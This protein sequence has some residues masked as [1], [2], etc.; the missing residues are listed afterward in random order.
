MFEL[1]SFLPILERLKNSELEKKTE[2]NKEL[3]NLIEEAITHH[4]DQ[5]IPYLLDLQND[6]HD[7]L[8]E[9]IFDDFKS[10]VT[11][12]ILE[13]IIIIESFWDLYRE[14]RGQGE[15]VQ[16]ALVLLFK[17]RPKI[18]EKILRDVLFRQLIRRRDNLQKIEKFKNKP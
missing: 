16:N 5:V 1:S 6:G 7:Q 12:N 10:L 4:P 8:L 9:I 17:H 18:G 13:E 14:S 2:A 3:L 11:Q 15:E